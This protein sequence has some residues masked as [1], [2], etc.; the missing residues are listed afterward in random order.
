MSLFGI[1]Q[2]ILEIFDI[3][4]SNYNEEP[5]FFK[6]KYNWENN[7]VY[8]RDLTIWLLCIIFTCI[9]W[10]SLYLHGIFRLVATFKDSQHEIKT[11]II[12]LYI[13]VLTFTIFSLIIILTLR[14]IVIISFDVANYLQIGVI[15]PSM[16][17]G[18]HMIYQFNRKLFKLVLD[19]K[20]TE[21]S[22]SQ[23]YS[24]NKYHFTQNQVRKLSIGVKH[25]ILG[26]S[27]GVFL[28]ITVLY[29]SAVVLIKFECEKYYAQNPFNYVWFS[30][31]VSMGRVLCMMMISYPVYLGFTVNKKY[32][33]VCCGC[34][35]RKLKSICGKMA[36]KRL[37]D[38]K[39][40][41]QMREHL[42]VE[43]T[44]DLTENTKSPRTSSH[45]SF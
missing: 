30:S 31:I 24:A 12:K 17:S 6:I 4:R 15:V 25:T 28:L 26:N 45:L 41:Y 23:S 36:M 27:L 43:L 20:G 13:F 38:K 9:W 39:Q 3:E 37:L 29:W 7:R 14:R 44:L 5:D 34:C 10:I 2:L 22:K 16:L 35:D 21:L 40:Y 32:Y 11:P 42:S 33:L 8:T 18:V 19:E 1:S